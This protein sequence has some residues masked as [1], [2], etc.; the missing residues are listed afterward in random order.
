M[1]SGVAVVVAALTEGV[2]EGT[3]AD[4]ST[5]AR[6]PGTPAGLSSTHWESPLPAAPSD[7]GHLSRTGPRKL[8]YGG[9]VVINHLSC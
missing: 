4:S 1:K 9:S 5:A 2:A 6:E 8:K 3:A 7:R